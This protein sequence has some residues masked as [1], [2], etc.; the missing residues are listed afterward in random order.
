MNKPI[1]VCY[2]DVRGMSKR[3]IFE[4]I[5]NTSA[6]LSNRNNTMYFVPVNENNRIECINP[7][8]ITGEEYKHVQEILDESQNKLNEFLKQ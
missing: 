6:H 4:H 2:V 1:L 7:V 3:E 5:S 8:L